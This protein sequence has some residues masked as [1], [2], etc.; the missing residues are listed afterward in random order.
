VARLASGVKISAWVYIYAADLN[1]AP[2]IP[3]G[4]FV[5]WLRASGSMR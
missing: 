5:Q 2:Q 3:S 1:G 4:D